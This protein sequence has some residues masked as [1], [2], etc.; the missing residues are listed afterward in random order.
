MPSYT[1]PL[2]DMQFVLHEVLKV[3]AD[4]PEMPPHA[5][6][7]ADTINAI[8]EEAGKF[9]AHVVQ[10]LN[11]VGDRQGCQLD[12]QSHAVK[13]P[14]GF[15]HAYQQYREAGWPALSCTPEFGGQ[16]LPH[17]VNQCFYE[18]LNASNQAWTMYPGLS[19]GA[20]EALL[21]HRGIRGLV[22]CCDD[23]QQDHYHD[24]DMLRANLLQLLIDGT[25]RPHEPA[26][27]PEPDSY[28]TWDYCRGYA[29][30]SLNGATSETDGY[31]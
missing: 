31:R 26:Y 22:V 21:A 19:H 15:A 8:L 5:E 23:C 9:A 28:V 13:T 30:A 17:V 12:V 3:T 2:R 6:V 4:Y 11:A 10:P 18:M 24:W 27:D 29:D 14:D 20:Y 1:P 7:D 16:G 25:V